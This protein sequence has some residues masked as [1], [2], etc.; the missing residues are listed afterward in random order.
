MTANLYHAIIGKQNVDD[1]QHLHLH[2]VQV[3]TVVYGQRSTVPGSQLH[4]K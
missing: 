2:Q 3:W 1:G 4:G